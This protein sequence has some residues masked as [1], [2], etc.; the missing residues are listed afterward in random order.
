MLTEKR[1]FAQAVKIA[2]HTNNSVIH[3]KYGLVA[4]A[5]S[6]SRY[7]SS[8]INA[9]H[10]YHIHSP[11]KQTLPEALCTAHHLIDISCVHVCVFLHV[12]VCVSVSVRVCCVC[13]Y[14]SVCVF[15]VCV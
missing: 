5:Q 8:T 3:Q 6:R 13:E 12:C 14:V 9:Q 2:P 4:K 1:N 11:S 7:C 15:A 10:A